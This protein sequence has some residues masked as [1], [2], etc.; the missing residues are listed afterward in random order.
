MYLNG[1]DTGWA[2]THCDRGPTEADIWTQTHNRKPC[3]EGSLARGFKEQWVAG[4]LA[5]SE[6]RRQAWS[7]PSETLG[8]NQF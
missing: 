8:R 1:V 4:I 5:L 6:A 3:G 7:K 2:V